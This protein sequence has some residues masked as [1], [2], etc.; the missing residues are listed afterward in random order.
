[1]NAQVKIETPTS[2]GYW[3]DGYG[4]TI[5]QVELLQQ[6]R[7]DSIDW[8]HIIGEIESMG[9]NEYNALESA[10]RV[11]L[12]HMLKWEYQPAFRSRRPTRRHRSRD[13]RD[14][15]HLERTVGSC[16]RLIASARSRCRQAWDLRPP[17]LHASYCRTASNNVSGINNVTLATTLIITRPWCKRG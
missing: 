16:Q 3:E 11:L 5:A 10:L 13:A 8:Q 7:F 15:E 14:V 6:K 1:M 17:L 12:T 2:P 4:W 9:S